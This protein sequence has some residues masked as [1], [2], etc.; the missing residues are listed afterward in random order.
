MLL[1][2][3][4]IGTIVIIIV[5]AGL[6][7]HLFGKHDVTWTQKDIDDGDKMYGFMCYKCEA[8]LED[9]EG[10]PRLCDKCK[11]EEINHA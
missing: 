8:E 7:F 11:E 9:G 1:A 3:N 10:Y 5:T 4:I 6:L 2:A